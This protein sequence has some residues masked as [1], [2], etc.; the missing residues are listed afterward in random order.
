MAETSQKD[1][2]EEAHR[3]DHAYQT[4]VLEL[5]SDEP[6]FGELML[7]YP[8]GR[9][10]PIRVGRSRAPKRGIID[11][12]HPIA[13]AFYEA[14]PGEVITLE[15]PY[16]GQEL[17]VLHR[18]K[19]AGEN[20]RLVQVILE[21][22]DGLHKLTAG[23]G[24]FHLQGEMGPAARD[25]A[26]L[27]DVTALLTQTQHALIT[28]S[29]ERPVIVQG[30]AGSGKTTV[31]L[32]RLSWLAYPHK[33]EGAPRVDP[34]RVLVVM[35][36]KALSSFIRRELE[37]LELEGVQLDTFHGWAL[38]E[39][40]RAYAGRIEPKP[41]S[42]EDAR[43]AAGLKKNVGVLSALE[44]FVDRQVD[45]AFTWLEEKL[46]PYD[47]E[48][49]LQKA[50]TLT[51][52]IAVRLRILRREALEA[53]NQASTRRD[54]ERLEQVRRVFDAA[55]RRMTQY[56]DELLR[57]L[58][59]RRLLADHLSGVGLWELE[60]LE[61]FQTGLQNLESSERRT[62]PYVAFED[63]ALLLRLIQL[64]NGGF[65][66]KSEDEQPLVYD[67]L[68]IDEAQDF[69][70]LE[71]KVLLAS[72]RSRT[73]VTVV[74]DLNQKIVPEADFIGWEAL[75]EELG[76]GGADVA[77]LEVTH[78]SSRPIV[79]L[80]DTLIDGY[81]PGGF[82][83][84]KPTLT[85]TA[86]LEDS[87]DRAAQL[88]RRFFSEQSDAHVCVVTYR[89][90]EADAVQA[91]LTPRLTG[92]SVRRGKNA[93]FTFEPGVTVTNMRQVKGLEFDMVVVLNPSPADYPVSDQGRRD[94]YTVLT[95][96][97]LQLHL[98][99][100]EDPTPLLDRAKKEGRLEVL[101]AAHVVPV[102]FNETDEEPF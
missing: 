101:D 16:K 94:L 44:A 53:R 7:E 21:R 43:I 65:P 83:G 19:V 4:D 92:V 12:R 78:R 102:V 100:H 41:I 60:A 13:D 1:A 24:G 70:A 2:L 72:V 38:Q 27:P 33:G 40:R 85:L 31:A 3:L 98:F 50:K 36:N 79:E 11:W 90:Q 14:D 20:R 23:P 18:A 49:W 29:L 15:A 84:P 64:K 5:R 99:G 63:F 97:R 91:A 48:V 88:I 8:D 9:T 82:A 93:S 54:G 67:H 25:V 69:G 52:P 32:Y 81:T 74:G 76:L 45:S 47:A 62:G 46:R 86:N 96:A 66:R 42:S 6:W 61:R 68:M 17:H 57:F 26:G 89:T 80:A 22:K 34:S 71:L 37:A 56:K 58:R 75:A 30:R 28:R 35:F 10:K 73:G 77:R 95:R 59:D 51:L 87:L 39:I 55:H